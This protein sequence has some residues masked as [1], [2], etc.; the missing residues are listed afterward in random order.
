MHRPGSASLPRLARLCAGLPL[1]AL[2]C[3]NAAPA[4][5]Q[6]AAPRAAVPEVVGTLPPP[7]AAVVGEGPPTPLAHLGKGV[8]GERQR[9]AP[10]VLP[11]GLDTVLH[12]A[13]EQNGQI[14]LAREKVRE[15]YAEQELAKSAWLPAINVGTAYYRHEGGIQ[16]ED[17]RLTHSSFGGLFSGMEIAGRLDLR[18]AVFAG[19]NA[20][21]KVWQQKGE[22]SRV[23]SEALLEAATTYID[24]LTARTGEAIVRQT[25]KDEEDILQQ[26]RDLLTAEPGA[27]FIAEGFEAEVFG[28]R[29]TAARLRQQ[30]DAAALKLAYLL[31]L[32]PDVQLVA[33]DPKLVPVELVSADAPT[34]QLVG[35]ALTSGPG[36][37][38]L[39]RL[40]G[41]INAA[42]EQAKGPGRFMPTVEMGVLEGLF[43]AGPGARMDF[44]NSLNVIVQARWNLTGLFTAEPTQRVAESRI[45][46]V[47][48]TYEDVRAKLA[49]GVEEAQQASRSG[50]DEMR[51]AAEAVRHAAE[52]YRLS[53]ERLKGHVQGST[54]SEVMGYIRGLQSAYLNYVGVVA[55]YDKAQLRL[56]VLTGAAGGDCRH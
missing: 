42:R 14:A 50:R 22:L 52:G 56:L 9:P 51:L 38:E 8:G 36:V 1:I 15:A 54:T 43:G 4:V 49:T 3:A 48:L 7:T 53:N 34:E 55:A 18:E 13:D 24:L 5:A 2:G 12:L 40:L 28:L 47:H 21:R 19:V 29:Q 16:N 37:R 10:K 39:E 27:R 35:Q 46:Q 25:L 17:G 26:A 45:Q 44:D 6:T 23:T 33:V 30:G 32:G 20:E 41:V 11:I 31:G